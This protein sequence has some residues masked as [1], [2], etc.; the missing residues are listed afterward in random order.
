MELWLHCWGERHALLV[1][2][3]RC[4]YRLD[5]PIDFRRHAAYSEKRAS[6]PPSPPLYLTLPHSSPPFTNF[7]PSP[8]HHHHKV[9]GCQTSI[10]QARPV[11]WP[12]HIMYF[13]RI[14]SVIVRSLLAYLKI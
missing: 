7:I 11:S 2:R 12:L 13:S 6:I 9:Y 8:D 4:T 3:R 1:A 5:L 14:V 10:R